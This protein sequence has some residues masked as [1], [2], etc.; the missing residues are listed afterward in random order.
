MSIGNAIGN[1]LF[2][3]LYISLVFGIIFYAYLTLR[4]VKI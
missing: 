1:D 4:Q 2:R 3:C